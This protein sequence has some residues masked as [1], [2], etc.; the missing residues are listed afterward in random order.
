VDDYSD[1]AESL[2]MMFRLFGFTVDVAKTTHKTIE[3]R[4]QFACTRSD[5]PNRADWTCDLRSAEAIDALPAKGLQD[6][7]QAA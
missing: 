1:S 7:K 4:C 2:A 3:E 5:P 6:Q